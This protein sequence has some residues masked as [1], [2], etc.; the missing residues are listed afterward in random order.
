MAKQLYI[1]KLIQLNNINENLIDLEKAYVK[2]VEENP[3]LNSKRI[4]LLKNDYLNPII[5]KR[6]EYSLILSKL[7]D[8][9]NSM[10]NKEKSLK[11]SKLSV[12]DNL[13]TEFIKLNDSNNLMKEKGDLYFRQSQI[14]RQQNYIF[15][16][17][18]HLLFLLVFILLISIFVI[19]ATVMGKVNKYICYLIIIAVISLYI[20]YLV[21]ILFVDTVNVNNFNF[22]KYNYNKPNQKE[23]EEGKKEEQDFQQIELDSESP[24]A[25]K[26]DHGDGIQFEIEDKL[27]ETVKS[28]A[29]LDSENCLV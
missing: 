11:E 7:V 29:N 24:C 3:D 22:R 20:L 21:K 15:D 19:I 27:L 13:L 16:Q 10:L 6:E 12:R 18:V 1:Q 4:E 5:S 9:S 28:D 8:S 26:V 23:L 25:Q 14:V 2:A 17:S